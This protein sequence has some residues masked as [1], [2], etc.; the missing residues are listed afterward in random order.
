MDGIDWGA[1]PMV[2]ELHGITDL[3]TFI[4]LLVAIRDYQAAQQD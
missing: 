3:E 4:A 2:S 1:L